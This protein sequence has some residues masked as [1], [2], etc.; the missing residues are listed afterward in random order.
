MT[1]NLILPLAQRDPANSLSI[2][3]APKKIVKTS[4]LCHGFDDVA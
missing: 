3:F 2:V 1:L 4:T